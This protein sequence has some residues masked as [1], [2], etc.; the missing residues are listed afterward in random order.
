VFRD[1]WERVWSKERNNALFY[2]AEIIVG[3]IFMLDLYKYKYDLDTNKSFRDAEM[4]RLSAL[5]RQAED[6]NTIN[7]CNLILSYIYDLNWSMIRQA[8][9]EQTQKTLFR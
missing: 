4:H 5:R 1:L 8:N 7:A 3:G 2:Y 9:Q 6:Q